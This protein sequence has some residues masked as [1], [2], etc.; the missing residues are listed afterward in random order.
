[1][2]ESVLERNLPPRQIGR[3]ASLAIGVHAVVIAAAVF[4]TARPTPI[5]DKEIRAFTIF[6]P[7]RV[8]QLGPIAGEGGSSTPKSR[9]EHRSVRSVVPDPDKN[10]KRAESSPPSASVNDDADHGTAEPGPA[11]D[12]PNT[13]A[14]GG[15]GANGAPGGTGATG[16]TTIALP[17]GE[18]MKRPVAIAQPAPTYSREASAARVEGT[19]SV[20]CVITVEGTLRDCRILKGVPYMDGAVLEVLSRW[21]Y[22]P[23]TFQ[24][25]P[26]SVF[27]AI[28]LRLVAP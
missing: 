26:V 4:A 15:P 21:K 11:A 3:G 28:N 10:R 18:G 22:T 27:Y 7:H 16:G 25:K 12:G 6:S 14:S 20:R 2:F 17:F 24:G 13:G 19:V 9:A 8:V 23:V 1:M 5:I